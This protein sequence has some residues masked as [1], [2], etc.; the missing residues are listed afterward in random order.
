MEVAELST[1]DGAV[2]KEGLS[3]TGKLIVRDL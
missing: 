2:T 3:G 1:E